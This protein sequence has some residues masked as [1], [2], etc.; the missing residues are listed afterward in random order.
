M[1]ISGVDKLQCGK[2]YSKYTKHAEHCFKRYNGRK[3]SLSTVRPHF[4]RGYI[5]PALG[6][7]VKKMQARMS[8]KCQNRCCKTCAINSYT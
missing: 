5:Y 4:S 6:N 2:N 7:T 1:D 8:S 3:A